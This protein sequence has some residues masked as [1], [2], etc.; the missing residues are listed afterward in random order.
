[1]QELPVPQKSKS[2]LKNKAVRYKER[3][4]SNGRF[5]MQDKSQA[6]ALEA[7]FP[8]TPLP[9][10]NIRLPIS[11]SMS[12]PNDLFLKWGFPWLPNWA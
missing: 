9:F 2:D 1:M 7:N 6:L 11:K 12:F 5:T 8:N 10:P 4:S 3:Y